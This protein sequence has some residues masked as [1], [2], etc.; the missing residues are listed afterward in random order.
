MVTKLQP[1]NET[2][3]T[4]HVPVSIVSLLTC[5]CCELKFDGY[6]VVF[7]CV[8]IGSFSNDGDDGQ[9]KRYVF[10]NVVAIIPSNVG[11]ISW[12]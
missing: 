1:S 6:I 12:S 4:A 5:I 2:I 11:E 7:I 3:P 9:R 10:S 8:N